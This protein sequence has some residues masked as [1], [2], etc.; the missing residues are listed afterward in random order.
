MGDSSSDDRVDRADDHVRLAVLAALRDV[1]GWRGDDVHDRFADIGGDSLLAVRVLARC[2]QA[3][4]VELPITL[5]T[6]GTSV[7]D[8]VESVRQA[9]AENTSTSPCSAAPRGGTGFGAV[10]LSAAQEAIFALHEQRPDLPV[11]NVPV[12]LDMY[13]ELDRTR[14]LVAISQLLRRHEALRCRFTTTEQGPVMTPHDTVQ[15][16]VDDVDLSALPQHVAEERAV[17]TAHELAVAPVD[18]GDLPIRFTLIRLRSDRHKLVLV[19]HHLV[20]DEWSLQNLVR[21]LV[22]LYGGGESAVLREMPMSFLATLREEHDRLTTER[23]A[24]LE[25]YWRCA[26]DGATHLLQLPLDR[27]RPAVRGFRGARL[28]FDVSEVE[29][30]RLREFAGENGT[31]LFSVLASGLALLLSGVTGQDD[32]LIGF[33]ASRRHRLETHELVGYLINM[34]PLRVRLPVEQRL[35][36]LVREVNKDVLVAYEHADLPLNHIADAVDVAPRPGHPPLVQVALVLAPRQDAVNQIPGLRVERQDL[37]TG[38]TKFDMSWYFEERGDGLSGYIEYDTEIFDLETVD[39][40]RHDLRVLLG[41]MGRGDQRIT[42]LLMPGTS[43]AEQLGVGDRPETS[44]DG[45]APSG[46][47]GIPES[48]DEDDVSQLVAWIEGLSDVQAAVELAGLDSG[49]ERE[50]P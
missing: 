17:R 41:N 38:T 26:L 25:Q 50:R 13:G 5:L 33:P 31:S 8:L 9:V 34:V 2:W 40:M 39:R 14:L 16:P 48:H 11:Y 29:G 49:R 23:K 21:D 18:I 46:A 27:P 19:L 47:G 10:R 15:V 22:E 20:C 24:E 28:P 6:A 30:A 7:A 12:V 32:L 45:K 4:D 37:G 44:A 42:D 36:Q 43:P 3:L 35:D 1:L